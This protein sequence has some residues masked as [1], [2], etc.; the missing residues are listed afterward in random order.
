MMGVDTNDRPV[1][2]ALLSD[3]HANR[4]AL[5]ACLADARAR[6]ATNY[7]FLGDLVGYGGEP[8]AVLDRVMDMAAH[9]AWVVRGNHDAAAIEVSRRSPD[10]DHTGAAWVARQLN[11]TQ[12]DFL[13]SLPLVLRKDF[14]LMVHASAHEPQRWDYVDDEIRAKASLDAA[15]A[16][17]ATH[18]FA[19]HVHE[20][21]LFFQ[22]TGRG[23]MAFEPTAG[24]PIPVPR[25]RRWLATVG[26]VGQ[27]RDGRRD[28]MYALFDSASMRLL[29]VRVPY[30]HE[31][32]AQAIRRAGLPEFF[33]QRLASGE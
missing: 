30:D 31:A 27:P 14:I 33:A 6:G 7:A 23:A 21:R 26:S 13:A 12:R 3:V 20:Q 18:V 28:A 32:A 24:V 8:V 29:F 17:D 19:G 4:H 5:D 2:L 22:G 10:A 9:G 1:K 25:H 15:S 16:Q 11:G